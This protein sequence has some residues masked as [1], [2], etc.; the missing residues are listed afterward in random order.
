MDETPGSIELRG[1]V[2]RGDR[3]LPARRPF[4]VRD[5]RGSRTSRPDLI[6]RIN[7]AKVQPIGRSD[8]PVSLERI[9]CRSSMSRRA[10]AAPGLACSNWCGS[11][12]RSRPSWGCP[13]PRSR[14]RWTTGPS[15]PSRTW[16]T[17]L[18]CAG[19]AELDAD[20]GTVRR[21]AEGGHGVLHG[22][23]HRAQADCGG[24]RGAA[25]HD[26][27]NAAESQHA[28]A[29]LELWSWARCS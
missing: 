17:A 25:S 6:T 13:R 7:R 2:L 24:A 9:R 23:R 1:V 18:G 5:S 20:P 28:G 27:R 16:R 19:S 22:H 11:C 15:P 26:R 4:A 3:L 8:V 21:Q 29:R 10:E 12:S 14:W